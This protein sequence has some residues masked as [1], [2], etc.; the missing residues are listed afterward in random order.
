LLEAYLFHAP[1]PVLASARAY[2]ILLFVK[3][4]GCWPEVK[5]HKSIQVP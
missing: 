5:L 1:F 4:T 2:P 3:L